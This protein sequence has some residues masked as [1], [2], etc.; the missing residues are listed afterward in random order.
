[1]EGR[2]GVQ[3]ILDTLLPPNRKAK[4]WDLFRQH[5]SMIRKGAEDDYHE[6]FG[7][8]FVEAYNAAVE[9]LSREQE[10][11]PPKR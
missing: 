3:S 11:P 9:R 4:L 8:A 5:F 6:L 1:L 2:L 7:K 10:E